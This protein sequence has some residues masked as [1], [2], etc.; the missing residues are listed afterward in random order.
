MTTVEYPPPPE[1]LINFILEDD[2]E[3]YKHF[4]LNVRYIYT[5]LD[6]LWKKINPENHT[7]LNMGIGNRTPKSLLGALNYKG[8][9]IKHIELDNERKV[10]ISDNE[11][12][13]WETDFFWLFKEKQ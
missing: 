4:D 13:I 10:S 8:V 5:Y 1:D 9:K 2:G 11:E 7:I 12:V 3:Q 6:T